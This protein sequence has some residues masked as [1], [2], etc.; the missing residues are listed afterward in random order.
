MEVSEL[1]HAP[2]ALPPPPER[3]PV[4]LNSM[5]YSVHTVMEPTLL[6]HRFL[7]LHVC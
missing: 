3:K 5:G 6:L 7:D 1:V 2:A 4:L